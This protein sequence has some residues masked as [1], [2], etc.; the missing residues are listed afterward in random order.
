[1]QPTIYIHG[2][3]A[4]KP[5]WRMAGPVD[6][7]MLPGEHI[8]LIGRNG[9]GKSMLADIITGAHPLLGTDVQLVGAVRSVTF[10]DCFGDGS[11]VLQQRWNSS[12]IDKEARS[13]GQLLADVPAESDEW[14]QRLY[15]MFSI[16]QEKDK[17]LVL[18]SSG[19]MRKFQL[20]RALLSCPRILMLDNPFIGLDHATREGLKELLGE[21]VA[22]MP[23]QVVLLLSKR[24]D[25][26]RFIT[27]I[28]EVED[29]RLGPKLTHEQW[30][31]ANKPSPALPFRPGAGTDG[32]DAPT[33]IDMRHV[34]IRYGERTILSDLNWTVREGERW[35]LSGPNGCGKSTLLSLVCADN[36]QSYACDI[37]LFGYERGSG[38]SIWDIKKHIGYVS[39][40]MHRAY[41]R[42]V[43]ALR[44]VASG[45]KDSV[46]LYMRPTE[47]EYEVCRK[48]MRVFG[49]EHLADR[50]FM[51]ISSGEQRLV[52]LAR[53]FVKDPALLILDE[54]LHGLDDWHCQRVKE[55]IDDYCR[56]PRKTMIMVS[57]YDDELPK[58]INRH[59]ELVRN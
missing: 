3:V 23:L 48:W 10:R 22:E 9:G 38:E 57:H 13:V 53:A 15:A 25:M 1:M 37:A 46:G 32:G 43:P 58:C 50:S 14:R 31:A 33:V 36:P 40:E 56:Q 55:I 35:W 28:I 59:K 42:P 7:E 27:H 44:I 34:Y 8:A 12:E 2:G 20:T 29:M 6:F 51:Q 21:L 16:E 45:L 4:R 11:Y 17:P 41:L 5:E 49:I 24:D 39:P 54:P 30:A 52:L 18:L 47:E 19:E 26:P